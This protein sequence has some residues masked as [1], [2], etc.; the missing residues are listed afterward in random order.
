MRPLA[1][2]AGVLAGAA[3]NAADIDV[4]VRTANGGPVRDAVVALHLVRQP[5]PPAKPGGSYA[6]DQQNIQ[7]HPFVSI[8]PVGASVAFMNHD[9]VR[10]HVYSFS[11]TKRFELKVNERQVN[12]VV[13]FD[14]AGIVPLGCN[15]HDQMIAF[16]DV[17]DTAWAAKT[18][19]SGTVSFH[20]VPATGVTIDVWHPYLRTPGNHVSRAATLV[21][22]PARREIFAVALRSPPRPPDASY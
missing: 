10:H 2:I 17:V 15:I 14:K 3:A 20:G 8:V 6:I 11:D 16:I 7:F 21:Q 9:A 22:G 5:T 1:A 13:T 19:A 12:R 18:D 4:Q